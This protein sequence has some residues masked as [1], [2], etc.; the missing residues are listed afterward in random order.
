MAAAGELVPS[1]LEDPLC[2]EQEIRGTVVAIDNFGNLITNIDAGLLARLRKA[3]VLA[4]GRRMP[5]C[6]T[7]GEA[8][9]GGFRP[10]S[11]PSA[12]WR[13]RVRKAAPRMAS[14]WVA[15]RR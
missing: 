6:R 9:P 1:L 8:Q 7:Y 12:C 14:G 5:V 2:S 15:A 10:C 11:I 4:G 3:E 13:L